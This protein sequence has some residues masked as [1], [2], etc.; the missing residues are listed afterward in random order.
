MTR[1]TLPM[2]HAPT[3][4]S[5][6]FSW[7]ELTLDYRC[8]LRCVGCR[9]CLGEGDSMTRNQM[10]KW[11][12]W[13]RRQ[14]ISSLWI[15]GGEPTLRDEL[16][17]LIQ[18]ARRAEY[19]TVLVQSNGLRLSYQAYAAALVKAGLTHVRLNVKSADPVLHDT[20]SGRPGTLSLVWQAM[21]HLRALGVSIAID[22]LLTT[23][24]IDGL[25][26]T[27]ETA[28]SKGARSAMLWLLSAHESDEPEVLS[29]VPKLSLV[30]ESLERAGRVAGRLGFEIQSL[31]T[32]A[33]TLPSTLRSLITPAASLKLLVANPAPE[34]MPIR[35][36]KLEESPIEGGAFLEGCADCRERPSC[37]GP[38]ADYLAAYGPDEFRPIG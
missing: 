35:A 33:C 30:A 36:F 25:A 15:G 32:P 26:E 12:A 19:D 34:G 16:P 38:R 14:G 28:A 13:G 18:S 8:N 9:A 37:S 11:L 10:A 4:T 27:I 31:H 29:R 3:L 2:A 17:A 5:S 6:G 23:E 22:V 7:L 24:T 20:L 21:D 1:P